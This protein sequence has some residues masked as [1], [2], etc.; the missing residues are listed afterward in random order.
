MPPRATT[1]TD[2]ASRKSDTADGLAR[3]APSS[4]G[5]DA[6]RVVAFLNDVEAAGLELHSFMLHRGGRVVAEAWWWPYGPRRPRI[7]HSLAKSLTACAVGLAIADGAFSLTDKVVSFFPERLPRVVSDN[8]AAMTVED[9]L[10][11]R[12]GHAAEVG[13]PLWRAIDSSWIDEFFKIPVVTPPGRT[14]MYSS[15]A[16]YMLAAILYR[17]TG[18]TLH[19]YLR[20]RLFAPLGVRDETWDTGPDG[21]N[22]GGNGFTGTTSD[23]L[24]LGALMAQDG[25]WDGRRLIPEAWM[26]TA[27]RGHADDGRYGYHWK[28]YPNGAFAAVGMFVQMALVMPEHEASFAVTA[29]IEESDLLVEHLFRH[30]PAGFR[31][32][33]FDGGAAD[34]RL[35]ARLAAIP[36]VRRVETEGV[37]AP[38]SRAAGLYRAAPNG[39]GV[40][41]IAFE[42]TDDALGFRLTDQAGSYVVGCGREAWIEGRT[43][44]PGR[45]LHHGYRLWDAPLVASA[46][47]RDAETLEMTWIFAETAFR[48]TVLCRF[49]G[50]S[51]TIDRSVNINSADRRWPT[52]TGRRVTDTP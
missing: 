36:A 1:S 40:T 44:M 35:A 33:P 12:T 16:S 22:P 23:I 48:D 47:W 34:A 3:G 45:S 24:K 20:P 38:W 15:A 52:I 50:D 14:F 26:R 31:S 13:G 37:A 46:R 21:F 28:T 7:M 43:N 29:A 49:E 8:L 10:T 51:V 41:E 42:P 19:A 27:T 5:V 30:F 6:D 4:V 39:L 17:T 2:D 32:A 9:L 18:Q 25:V 11:M